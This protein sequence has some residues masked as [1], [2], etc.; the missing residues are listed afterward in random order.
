MSL[1]DVQPVAYTLHLNHF[2]AY[3][4]QNKQH[5]V[6]AFCAAESSSRGQIICPC[7]TGKTIM[8]IC[9]HLSDMINKTK[10]NKT[11][12]YGTISHRLVLNNQLCDELIDVAVK[13]GLSFDILYIGSGDPNTNKYYAG[14]AYLGYH[15]KLSRHLTTLDQK[16]IDAFV[17]KSK[18][19]GRHVIIISTYNSIG[20]LHNIVLNLFDYI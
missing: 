4:K 17:Q 5:Q 9:L 1:R 11:G 18:E 6:E 7:A 8:Q 19:L 12:V 15:S 2:D 16:E 14:Y 20:L 10:A 13:C 3:F